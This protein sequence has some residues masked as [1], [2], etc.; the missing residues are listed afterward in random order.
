MMI[1]SPIAIPL[2]QS[3]LHSAQH[4][5]QVSDGAPAKPQE[6]PA[7]QEKAGPVTQSKEELAA[8]SV[9]DLKGILRERGVDMTGIAEKGELVQLI[10]E[11]CT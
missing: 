10:L 3:V 4:W 7:P 1:S 11:R 9:H 6:K 2:K 8:M 5:V